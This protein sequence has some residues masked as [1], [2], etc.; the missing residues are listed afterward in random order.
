MG[1]I[2]LSNAVIPVPGLFLPVLGLFF[3]VPGLF[4]TV[5]GTNFTVPGPLFVVPGTIGQL[6]IWQATK[7]VPH[8]EVTGST[9]FAIESAPHG[10]LSKIKYSAGK[11][12][13]MT[14]AA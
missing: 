10:T 5:P 6:P 4:F 9:G 3:T 1:T 12:N 13:T 2:F 8:M 14:T 11:P 7:L